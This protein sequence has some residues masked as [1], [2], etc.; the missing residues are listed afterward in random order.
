MH[1]F[2]AIL[3]LWALHI[4]RASPQRRGIRLMLFSVAACFSF[5][6]RTESR[7]VFS[8]THISVTTCDTCAM[9]HVVRFTRPSPTVF[10][11]CKQSRTGGGE[12]LAM[13][14]VQSTSVKWSY[15]YKSQFLKVDAN[16]QLPFKAL[17]EGAGHKMGPN[18]CMVVWPATSRCS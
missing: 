10:V 11:Y 6:A 15:C 3:S 5:T 16:I 2:F 7:S 4:W 12:G 13:W 18:N 17:F 9:D 8:T 14:L 1:L